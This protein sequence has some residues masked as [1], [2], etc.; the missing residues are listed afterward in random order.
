M[1]VLAWALGACTESAGPVKDTQATSPRAQAAPLTEAALIVHADA[2]GAP[3]F[4]TGALGT[5]PEAPDM[6]SAEAPPG[7]ALDGVASHFQLAPDNLALQR[8]SVDP[9]GDT[10]YRYSVLFNGLPIL[11]AELRVHVR[12][13][14][15]FA[16]NTNVHGGLRGPDTPRVTPEEA[17][18]SALEDRESPPDAQAPLPPRLVYYRVE[19]A[20][21]LVHEVRVSGTLEDG[22]PLDDSVLVDAL[23]GSVLVRRSHVHPGLHR[24][25]HDGK[26]LIS[27]PGVLVRAEG[28]GPVAD[29][30]ANLQYTH[31]GTTHGCYS[32]LFGRNS[33]DNAGAP[34]V[35]TVHHLVKYP[36]AFWNGTQL[37]FGDGDGVLY[38]NLA[39][40]L[41][42][43]AHEFTH[44][45]TDT[46]SDLAYLGES[47]SLNESLSDIFGA[48]CEWYGDGKVLS[49]RTWK[50]GE[51]FWTPGVSGDALRYMNSPTLDGKSVDYFPDYTSGM[52]EH[53]GS[54]IANLAFY[55]LS[56]GGSHPRSKTTTVVPAIGIEKAA[57]IFY[58]ANTDLLLPTA[59]FESAKVATEQAAQQLGYDA[60]TVAAVTKAWQAVGVGIP[61][62]PPPSPPLSKNVPMG[63]LSGLRAQKQYFSVQVPEGAYD[64]KFTLTALQGGSG[65]ADLYVKFGALPTTSS[66]DCRP[67]KPGSEESCLFATAKKGTYYVMLNGF[68]NYSGLT[69]TVTW[70]GGY[71]SI[72]NGVA[73]TG[74][75]DTPG[76]AQLFQL[77]VP[78][79]KN[80]ETNNVHVRLFGG[81]G[82]VD[83]YVQRTSAPTLF[84]YDCRDVKEHTLEQCLLNDVMPGNYFIL[85]YGAKGGY[86]NVTLE[87]THQ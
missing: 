82:N 55:L 4:I 80:G 44:A 1:M 69:L 76:S 30:V 42:I 56:Q 39:S 13:R 43:T 66:Y 5:F 47:G 35:S 16:I 84:A 29:S 36:N 68:S 78:A 45:V 83:L 12:D 9:Q 81:S 70:K 51:D 28:Q 58:K 19:D 25:V 71:L 74:L 46:E 15:I 33:Y 87:A 86:S 32:Q 14:Q 23:E 24:L 73:V 2:R 62:P 63:G 26:S 17:V 34:L 7:A 79:R 21:R 27:L 53:Y 57:R 10:H 61:P 20:L 59:T 6:Q 41:D 75:S 67:Y 54:G 48:V 3:T 22:T 11:D 85:L 50:L 8:V 64:L 72:E 18:R 38:G 65:D 40:A 37:A 31:L 49:Q 60:D 77:V 52:D